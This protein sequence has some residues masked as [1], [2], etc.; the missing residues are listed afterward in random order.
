MSLLAFVAATTILHQTITTKMDGK[1]DAREQAVV[2][3]IDGEKFRSVGPDDMSFFYGKFAENGIVPDFE[4]PAD[5]PD[6][7]AAAEYLARY[8]RFFPTRPL[9][10]LR[11]LAYQHSAVGRDLLPEILIRL[12]A[13]AHGARMAIDALK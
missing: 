9:A 2:T 10:G 8:E 13:D 4:A 3:S 11:L 12:G 1:P 5:A 6:P 7:A